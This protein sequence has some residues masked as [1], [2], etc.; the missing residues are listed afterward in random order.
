MSKIPVF[1]VGPTDSLMNVVCMMRES[2]QQDYMTTQPI[3]AATASEAMADGAS[4]VDEVLST[5]MTQFFQFTDMPNE[6]I[7]VVLTI[8]A[9]EDESLCWHLSMGI[10]SKSAN[11]EPRRV[12]NALA[13]RLANSFEVT[14]ES[15]PEGAFRNVRHFRAT[16]RPE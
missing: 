4:Q 3:Y 14:T 6:F 13:K 5:G 9:F 10:S 15:P 16:Y 1:R 7:S 8:D 12:P 11:E 2:A